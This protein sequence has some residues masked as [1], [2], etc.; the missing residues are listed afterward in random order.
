MAD[1]SPRSSH[2]LVLYP[3]VTVGEVYLSLA[4]FPKVVLAYLSSHQ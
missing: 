3:L 4:G 1:H 2:F